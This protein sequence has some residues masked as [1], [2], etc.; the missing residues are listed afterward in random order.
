MSPKTK[1][2]MMRS[3]YRRI[4]REILDT[5]T[6]TLR[7]IVSEARGHGS[8]NTS[9]EGDNGPFQYTPLTSASSFRILHLKHKSLLAYT[10]DDKDT[11]LCG[12]LIEASIDHPPEYYALSYTWGDPALCES[13]EIDGKRLAITASCA[14]AL[15]RMLRGKARRYIWVDSI[16]INQGSTP[17]ALKERGM[18][19]PMMGDIYQKAI[20]VNV[21]L[22]DGDTASD[23]ACVALKKLATYSIGALAPG[24]QQEFFRRKYDRL[25]DDVLAITPEYPYGKLHGVFRLPWFRRIWVVQE[26]ALGRNVMFYCGKHLI[27]L[28]MLVAG[29]D[30]AR[31]PYSRLDS[32]VVNRHWISYLEYHDWINELLRRKEQGEPPSNFGLTL[33]GVLMVPALLFEATRPEDKIHGLYNICKRFGFELPAPDYTKP[34]AAVY[35]EATRAIIRDEQGLGILSSVIESPGWDWRLPSW[36]PNFSGCIRKWSPSSPPHIGLVGKGNRAVSGHTAWQYEF[37]L[38]GQALSVKGRRL[39]ILG[40]S[41][42]PWMTDA[43]TNMLGDSPVQTGQVIESFIVCIGSWLDVVQGHGNCQDALVTM[44]TLVQTLIDSSPKP[45]YLSTED[46]ESV[47]RD[48]CTLMAILRSDSESRQ[49]FLAGLQDSPPDNLREGDYLLS[50]NKLLEFCGKM[51]VNHWR[52]VF[53]TVGGYLGL[54]AH[55]VRDGDIVVVFHGS[56]LPAVIRPCEGW[57]RYVGPANV[58]GIMNGEFWSATSAADDESFILI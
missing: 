55:T 20:Q 23:V 47:V 46:L 43:S 14:A 26:V 34:V 1:P 7:E 31:I 36:A 10:G 13:I 38:D 33:A 42:L 51:I 15:R 52:T 11:Q 58:G 21:H 12:S 19:V 37:V 9:T 24:P 56:S 54:G 40:A 28:K 27:H 48:L 44:T 18:Q 3:S 49:A 53:R 17:E 8:P 16:C 25:A 22:S 30:F 32:S 29:A 6:A 45:V 50:P 4:G 5:V 39:D 57:F 35:A 41:G 2:V